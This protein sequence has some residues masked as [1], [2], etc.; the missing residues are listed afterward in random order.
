[1]NVCHLLVLILL[2]A[3]WNC[4]GPLWDLLHMRTGE[5]GTS[6]LYLFVILLG[7]SLTMFISLVLLHQF[8]PF[9]ILSTHVIQSLEA[10]ADLELVDW[11]RSFLERTAQE[12]IKL[13]PVAYTMIAMAVACETATVPVVD[14]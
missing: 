14:N 9:L 4:S 11:V 1:M 5:L 12:R 10:N 6:P 2:G 7:K 8:I 3:H 13:R